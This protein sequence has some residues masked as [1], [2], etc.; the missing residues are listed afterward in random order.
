MIA[1]KLSSALDVFAVKSPALIGVDISSTSIKLVELGGSPKAL[2][3]Q[4]LAI[5]DVPQATPESPA[6]DN[7]QA[8]AGLPVVFVRNTGIMG[9]KFIA[10]DLGFFVC[11]QG[12]PEAFFG[13]RTHLLVM[14]AVLYLFHRS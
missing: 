1:E 14:P 3:I 10:V 9:E 2:K 6:N 13:I 4:R 12:F 8:H 7:P 5:R 11:V